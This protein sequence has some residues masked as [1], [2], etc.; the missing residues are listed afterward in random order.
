MVKKQNARMRISIEHEMGN[1]DGFPVIRRDDRSI[2]LSGMTIDKRQ[3]DKILTDH[4]LFGEILQRHPK[5][6]ATIVSEVLAGRHESA[7]SKA[8]AIG[9]TEEIFRQKSGGLIGWIVVVVIIIIIV[10]YPT[11]A[12]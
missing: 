5:E 12:Q 8:Q 7:R 11:P 6:I 2:D 3:L 1:L 10:S 9:L 4:R